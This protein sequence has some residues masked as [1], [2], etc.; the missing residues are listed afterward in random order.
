M[1]Q[2]KNF[3]I[4]ALLCVIAW[5]STEMFLKKDVKDESA[6]QTSSQQIKAQALFEKPDAL[7]LERDQAIKE[8]PRIALKTKNLEG[9]V[10][11]KGALL[12]DVTLKNYPDQSKKGAFHLLSPYATQSGYFVTW[13][14]YS[15]KE[16]DLPN[17]DAIWQADAEVL[18]ENHP[19]TLTWKNAQ[20]VVF[21]Q[22][23]SVDENYMISVQQ[24]IENASNTQIAL[25]A[26][27]ELTRKTPIDLAG[28]FVSHEGALG[29][30]QGQLKEI[31]YS[32]LTK[33]PVILSLT[34]DGG[35]FGFGDK[36][37]L[38]A[39][40]PHLSAS[41][42]KK[43]GDLFALSYPKTQFQQVDKSYVVSLFYPS[44]TVKPGENFS[45]S[46]DCFVGPKALRLLDAYEASH[47]IP[48]FDLAVDFGWF[49]FL[50]KPMLKTLMFLKDVLGSFAWAIIVLTIFI[51]AL[52]FPLA[53]KSFR[54]MAK[55]KQLQPKMQKLKERYANDK[56]KLNQ[57]LMQLYKEAKINPASGCLPMIVQIPVFFALYKVLFVSI[58]MR[59]A[60]FYGWITDLSSPDPTTIFNLFGLLP[61]NVPSALQV[62]VWPLLMGLS[63]LLQQRVNGMPSS[64]P[65]QKAM[66]LYVMPVLFSYMLSQFPVGLVIYWTLSNML[67]VLQQFII[68]KWAQRAGQ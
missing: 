21:K 32:D 36:Y 2:Q 14:W 40:I 5:L 37:W 42:Q 49:Y 26:K 18:S 60:P 61:Y 11:L 67:T 59:N 23:W 53:I 30:A 33:G 47:H 15:E 34:Q 68:S 25:G 12:D 43:G 1:N 51:K 24:K 63:M 17:H 6:V 13:A 19:V 64:D 4:A 31:S 41:G 16:A 35:W 66:F 27:V 9:S 55:M 58:E 54:S 38:T 22:I 48:H 20:G 44:I 50:T 62:G 10:L 28:H 52:F 39:L 7:P 3:F 8:G 29:F 57:E 56:M 45:F 46:T 65:V